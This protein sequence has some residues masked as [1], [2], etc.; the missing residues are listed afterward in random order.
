MSEEKPI[1]CHITLKFSQHQDK[2][3]TVKPSREKKNK[4]N[5]TGISY[6]L[7]QKLSIKLQKIEHNTLFSEIDLRIV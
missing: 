4:K 6:T 3:N 2:E 1:L 5:F 7:K